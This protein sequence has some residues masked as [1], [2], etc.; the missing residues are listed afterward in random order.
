M[1]HRTLV[2]SSGIF[3]FSSTEVMEVLKEK[4]LLS[5]IGVQVVIAMIIGTAVG[6]MMGDSATMF[7][8]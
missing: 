7:A 1:V 3:I 4:S 8:P 2:S 6:A 5:N